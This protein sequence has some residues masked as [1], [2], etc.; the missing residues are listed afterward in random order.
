MATMVP[1]PRH[2]RIQQL[3][4]MLRNK[5]SLLK[6]EN[7]IASIFITLAILRHDALLMHRACVF[8]SCVNGQHWEYHTL[9]GRRW[10]Y[11]SLSKR[12]WEYNM[13]LSACAESMIVSA[14]SAESMWYN[15]LSAVW[16]CYYAN[17]GAM[18][19][20]KKNNSR[21]TDN[22]RF[23]TLV[24]STST[25]VPI[26]LPLKTAKFCHT[27]NRLLVGRWCHHTLWQLQF[28]S[29]V[30]SHWSVGWSVV[31]KGSRALGGFPPKGWFWNYMVCIVL[32][33]MHLPFFCSGFEFP[34][35][36]DFAVMYGS[37]GLHG[38]PSM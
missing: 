21:D 4:N 5:S 38:S 12:H 10:E 14:L 37:S 24:K 18:G 7:T 28:N 25:A 27:S 32:L 3:A 2:C 36:H 34:L 17:S 20:Y 30:V 15:T 26:G 33:E 35:W 16:L 29:S 9:S 19:G 1:S 22:C 11:C 23:T 8:A 6:L 13:M 31:N